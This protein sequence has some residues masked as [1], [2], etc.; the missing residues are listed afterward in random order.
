MAARLTVEEAAGTYESAMR[1]VPPAKQGAICATCRTFIGGNYASCLACSRQP[2]LLDAVVPITY[3]EHLGQIHDAL[4]GYKDGVPQVQSYAMP[5][6]AAI[7]WRF[8][9]RHE[10]CVGRAAGAPTFD[11][12]T[13]VPSSTMAADERRSNFRTIVGW[14]RP[15]A[16]RYERVLAATDAVPSG[17]AFA[18]YRYETA[19]EIDGAAVLLLDDTWVSGGHAQSACASLKGAG[20]SIVALVVIGRHVQRNWEVVPGGSTSGEALDTLP[21]RFDWEQCTVHA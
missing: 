3:S 20:A 7:L 12:V 11:I 9:A 5:R 18:D 19:H 6:L 10:D 15:V 4:R 2:A 1:N 16:A 21:R 17:R 13:T 14:C 8:L